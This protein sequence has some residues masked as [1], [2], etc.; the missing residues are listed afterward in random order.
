[1]YQKVNLGE[2]NLRKISPLPS[3]HKLNQAQLNYTTI[4]QEVVSIMEIL[5][6]YRYILQGHN[7]VIFT[8]RKNLSFSNFVSSR[9]LRWRLMIEEFGPSI[10][11]IKGSHNTVADVLSRSPY[12]ESCSVEEFFAATQY[13]TSDEFQVFFAIISKYQLKG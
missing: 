8:D 10:Q 4:E 13:D 5:R 2:S 3:I 1:M 6:E 11:Y 12:S 9:V 7:V